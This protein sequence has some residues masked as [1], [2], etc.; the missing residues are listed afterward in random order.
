MFAYCGIGNHSYPPSPEIYGI[1]VRNDL[2]I[3]PIKSFIQI[4]EKFGAHGFSEVP[5]LSFSLFRM[6]QC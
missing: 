5:A 2:F 6:H 3:A 4:A 1:G